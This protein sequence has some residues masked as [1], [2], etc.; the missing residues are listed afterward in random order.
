MRSYDHKEIFS[1]FL[2]VCFEIYIAILLF[3]I[4]CGDISRSLHIIILLNMN[5]IS[6]NMLLWIIYN[7]WLLVYPKK[8][9]NKNKQKRP[10]PT[11]DVINIYM[12]LYLYIID[13]IRTE[14]MDTRKKGM[15]FISSACKFICCLK[16]PFKTKYNSTQMYHVKQRTYH[17]CLLYLLL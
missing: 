14:W 16:F 11:T 13:C 9:K 1:I 10:I 8:K 4:G 2:C 15:I 12:K 3:L 5:S 7:K 6:S 17:T